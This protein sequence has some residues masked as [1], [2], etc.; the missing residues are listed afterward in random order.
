MGCTEVSRCKRVDN[1]FIRVNFLAF[2]NMCHCIMFIMFYLDIHLEDKT[3]VWLGARLRVVSHLSWFKGYWSLLQAPFALHSICLYWYD[4][5]HMFWYLVPVPCWL[6]L[7][8]ARQDDRRRSSL[9]WR[10][11]VDSPLSYTVAG[12]DYLLHEPP[13]RLCHSHPCPCTLSA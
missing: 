7:A 11:G 13:R 2:I 4:H 10:S 3:S 5:D 12:R 8:Q 9:S 1:W 6:K